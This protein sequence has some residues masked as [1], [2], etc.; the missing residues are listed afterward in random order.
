[1]KTRDKPTN[2]CW[3][4]L[5]QRI[6][7]I[8]AFLL[9]PII[10]VALYTSTPKSTPQAATTIVQPYSADKKPKPNISLPIRIKI[11]KIGVDA[12]IRYSGLTPD[13]AMAIEKNPDEV[14]W[15]QLGPRPG[16]IGSAV[17]AG[18]YGFLNG[19]GSVFNRLNTLRAGDKIQ[20]VDEIGITTVFVVR[21]SQTYTPTADASDVFKSNDGTA[22]LNLITC[23]GTWQNAE[24]TYSNR[25]VVFAD[26]EII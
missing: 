21:T 24:Q 9:L 20:T 3:R 13:G 11:P 26:K 17:I 25:L 12:V 2:Q 16:E 15:Y 22:H 18:H 4:T 14:A 1:M 10:F 8:G 6:L 5:S 23:D 19:I 7:L